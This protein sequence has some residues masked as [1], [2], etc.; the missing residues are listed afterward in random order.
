M[1]VYTAWCQWWLYLERWLLCSNLVLL[2]VIL[3]LTRVRF[4]H[5]PGAG[6]VFF[7]CWSLS[8]FQFSNGE[9]SDHC[10]YILAFV[11]LT[12]MILCSAT[13]HPDW[14][15]LCL[16]SLPPQ[17]QIRSLSHP[18][19]MPCVT[20]FSLTV[21]GKQGDRFPTSQQGWNSHGLLWGKALLY[22]STE[23][24][25]ISQDAQ[26]CQNWGRNLGLSKKPP[27]QIHLSFQFSE[28]FVLFP[29]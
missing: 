29:N 6:M 3:F 21:G 25:S 15:L 22:D 26:H 5:V 18:Q 13:S 4:G 27:F 2:L 23:R 16:L 1:W 19:V 14:P 9:Y 17:T 8:V 20:Q 24:S 12:C 11:I 10:C 28:I 7:P